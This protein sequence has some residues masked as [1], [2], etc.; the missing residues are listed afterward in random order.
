MKKVIVMMALV[1]CG[2][3]LAMAETLQLCKRP[4]NPIF[5]SRV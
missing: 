4:T 1:L 3:S 2:S 5:H